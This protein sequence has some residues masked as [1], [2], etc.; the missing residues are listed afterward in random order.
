[1][2]PEIWD[3]LAPTE[4]PSVR[5]C[6]SCRERVYFCATDEQ[7]R[8]HARAGHCIARAEPHPSEIVERPPSQRPI[9]LGRPSMP[10]PEPEPPWEP[11]LANRLSAREHAITLV[12]NDE[13]GPDDRPCPECGWD[14]E[15]W[16][17]SCTVCG[18][19]LG[20]GPRLPRP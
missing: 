16:R 5:Y 12:L 14:V 6:G 3:D 13:R 8:A 19:P 9:V 20:R 11:P 2:C 1:M 10:L 4:D 7:T 17:P 18:H 15:Q